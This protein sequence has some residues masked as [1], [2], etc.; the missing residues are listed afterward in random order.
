MKTIHELFNNPALRKFF[1]VLRLP[2]SLLALMA[3]V[4]IMQR[5]WFY[6]GLAL[7]FLGACLQWWCFACLKKQKVLAFNGPYGFVRN[8][9]YLGRYLLL[10]G[11][12]LMTGN[13]WLLAGFSLLYFFYMVNR[14]SREEKTLTGI[15]GADYE[16][17][18]REIPRFIPSWKHHPK[19]QAAY[20]SWSTFKGN[21]G[22]LNALA[23]VAA[24]AACWLYL[25]RVAV[26]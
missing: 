16:A 7:S 12:V 1:L 14:V 22:P 8:P 5:E 17:Y 15:F 23:V 11:A 2:L 4:T 20:F 26:E 3:L 18:C 13:L 10:A 9:M 21:H 19:G 6:G 25:F 24:Y